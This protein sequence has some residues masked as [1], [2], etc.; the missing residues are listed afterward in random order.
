MT[1]TTERRNP[2]SIGIDARP[3]EEILGVINAEDAGIARVVGGQIPRI[4]EAAEAV[5]AAVSGGGRVF[6]V[7]AGTSGRLGVIE[8]AEMPPT[9]GLPG[10]AFQGIIAGGPEAVFRSA[11]AAEDDEAS[12]TAA[13]DERGFGP[14][15]L[16]IALSASGGTPF[17]LGALKRARGLGARTVS[18]TCNRGAAVSGLAEV[19]IVVEVGPEVVA[20]ST[21]MKAGTAQKLIL[22]MITAAAMARLGR[23]YDGYMVGVQ[24]TSAKL[25]ERGERIVMEIASIEREEA[26]GALEGSG[27]DVRVAV[28]MAMSGASP[29]E[30]RRTLE[31][32]GGSLRRA[33]EG[34]G[35]GAS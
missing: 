4:A 32:A 20:G 22:N 31:D 33:L 24:V 30:A 35:A 5:A 15:D 7:G 3:V 8:A 9:F 6:F 29:E 14:L 16:L 12:G 1:R 10:E 11:E 19:P 34:L 17:V 27:G 28:I 2:S 26:A 21:R 18:V 13:L 25:R 23:V